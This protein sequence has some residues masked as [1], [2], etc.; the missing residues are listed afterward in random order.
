VAV[1]PGMT[2]LGRAAPM[3][4]NVIAPRGTRGYRTPRCITCGLR[5]AEP[6]GYRG[7]QATC[8]CTLWSKLAV[9][10]EVC[11][12]MARSEANKPTNTGRLLSL[13]LEGCSVQIRGERQYVQHEHDPHGHHAG[14]AGMTT[15]H[16]KELATWAEE[17]TAVLFPSPN[18]I[19]IEELPRPRR[20]IVPDGCWS[21]ARRIMTKNLNPLGLPHVQLTVLTPGSYALRRGAAQSL[22]TFEAVTAALR[23]W[24]A[25]ETTAELT[26]RFEDWHTRALALRG[27]PVVPRPA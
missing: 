13:W 15:V 9:Q 20:L 18:A 4:S 23:C 17:G 14:Q 3:L 10:T 19:P 1:E 26:R 21:Q 6:D 25:P 8:V 7:H 12:L 27:G 11:V 2:W 5:V 22:C 16:S 24:E